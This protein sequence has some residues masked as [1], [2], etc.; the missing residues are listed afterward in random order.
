MIGLGFKEASELG[1]NSVF[2]TLSNDPNG[3]ILTGGLDFAFTFSQ[4]GAELVFGGSDFNKFVGELHFYELATSVSTLRVVP[5]LRLHRYDTGFMA[6]PI[7][8]YLNQRKGHKRQ[9]GYNYR[10][11]QPLCLW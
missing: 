6:G 10:L 9:S 1:A 7:G 3:L 8:F 11:G 5:C 4:Q 2:D